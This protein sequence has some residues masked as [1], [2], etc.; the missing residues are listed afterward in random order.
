M[1]TSLGGTK[2]WRREW[3]SFTGSRNFK[4]LCRKQAQ[5]IAVEPLAAFSYSPW[6]SANRRRFQR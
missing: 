1:H 2:D 6:L 4:H 3:E 5:A